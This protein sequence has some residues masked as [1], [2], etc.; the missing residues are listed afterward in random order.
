MSHSQGGRGD[1]RDAPQSSFGRYIATFRSFNRTVRLFLTVTAFRG[2]VIATLQTVLNLYLYSLGYDTRF[3]GFINGVNAIATLFCSL[4]LGFLADR[5]GRKPILLAGGLLYPL[6]IL[7][8][9]VSTSTSALLFFSFLWGGVSS[10][11]WVAGVPLLVANT[12]HR[13]RVQAFSINSFL[14]WGLGPFGALFSGQ[15]VELAARLMHVSSSSAGALRYGMFCMVVMATLGSIPYL[16]MQ[17][18]SRPEPAQR[19]DPLPRG[20]VVGLFGRLLLPDVILTFGGGAILGFIQL[21]YHLRFGLSAGSIGIIMAVAGIVSGIGTLLVP[22]LARRWGNLRTTVRLLWTA[23]PL[24]AALAFAMHLYVAI[25][26]YL[27]M[28]TLRSMFDPVYTAFAQEQ[29][30]EQYRGR[31]T[32][33]YSVTFS[34]GYSLGPLLSGQIQ[35]AA[36]FTPAFLVGTV[37]YL[38]GASLLYIFFGRS[39]SRDTKPYAGAA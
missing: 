17:E 11:Y 8:I 12:D 36:G 26:A 7:A 37:C 24:M 4:G 32:G 35:R 25:P 15:I 27:L 22:L 13:Q 20:A 10:A 38:F 28:L 14:L 21:Y 9:S 3:I 31:L 18:A 23:A 39:G 30:P 5:F 34:I 33:M 6:S 2:L 19:K 29:V 1:V 16:F